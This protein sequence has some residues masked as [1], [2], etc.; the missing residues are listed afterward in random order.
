MRTGFEPAYNGFASLT[1]VVRR[2]GASA[3]TASADP[4]IA[5]ILD[6]SDTREPEH[7]AASSRDGVDNG[8]HDHALV[9]DRTTLS[10]NED[11]RARLAEL[12]AEAA[13]V[14]DDDELRDMLDEARKR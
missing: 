11:R 10:T 13:E 4:S 14:F 6:E 5:P 1:V 7:D 12:L 2:S 3:S 8:P 9:R